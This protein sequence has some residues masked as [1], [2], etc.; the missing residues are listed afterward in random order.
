MAELKNKLSID[1]GDFVSGLQKAE[2]S[3]ETLVDK[4]KDITGAVKESGDAAQEAS[5]SFDLW[6][7]AV[8]SA[9]GGGVASVIQGAASKI[10]DFGKVAFDEYKKLDTSINNIGTL[11]VEA[12]GLSLDE[13]KRLATE[14]STSLPDTAGNIANGIYNAISAGIT[15]T[16]E[17]IAGFVEIAGKVAVAGLSDTNTAVNALTSV[18][19]AYGLGVEGADQVSNTF[20]AAIKAGKTSF[21]ELNAGLANVVPAASAAG[22]GFDEVAGSIAKLTTVG[23]PTSQATTQ[24]RSAIIEL[25]KPSKPLA[26]AL[27]K[28]GLDASNMA[29]ELAKPREQGGGLVN[30]LQR[31]EKSAAETGQSMTQI[32]SSSEAASAALSLTGKNAESTNQILKNVS[33][34]I[35]DNVAGKAFDAAAKS[36]DVQLKIFQNNIQAAFNSIF[37]AVIPVIETV[38]GI[39]TDVLGP[40]IGDFVDSIGQYFSNLGSILQP[41]LAVVGGVIIGSIVN[42]LNVVIN[43]LTAVYDIANNTFSAVVEAVRPLAEAF[44]LVGDESEESTDYVAAFKEALT[45]IGEVIK[46]VADILVGAFK[47]AIELAT[48]PLS[49]IA[50]VAA[51]VVDWFGSLFS[52]TKDVSKA[53]GDSVPFI[54]Q[55]RNVLDL[56]QKGAQGVINVF[57]VVKQTIIDVAKAIANL[58]FAAVLES[59]TGFGDKASAAYAKAFETKPVEDQT[60]TVEENT[61]AAD[62]NAAAQNKVADGLDKKGKSAKK[63]GDNIAKLT[64]ELRKLQLAEE[65]AAEIEAA[66]TIADATARQLAILEIEKKYARIGLEEELAAIKGNSKEAILQREILNAKLLAIDRDYE[67]K[68]QKVVSAENTKQFDQELALRKRT[69]ESIKK[70]NSELVASLQEQVGLGNVGAV[71]QLVA[72]NRAAIDQELSASIDAVTEST[73]EFKAGLDE[74]RRQLSVGLIDTDAARVQADLLRQTILE[75]LLAVPGDSD[76]FA[77]EIRKLY[78]DAAESVREAEAAVLDSAEESRIRRI[79]S[80]LLRDIALRVREIEKER[81]LLLENTELTEEQRKTI[82]DAYSDQIEAARRGPLRDFGTALEGILQTVESFT[83]DF[84][85]EEAVAASDEIKKKQEE[86]ND[87][88]RSGEISYQDAIERL[89]ELE[90]A[91]EQ[92]QSVLSQA[93]TQALQATAESAREQV[94][95]SLDAYATLQAES[96]KVAQDE[97]LTAD[98]KRAEL[99]SI[100]EK[101]A[102]QQ[103]DIYAQIGLQAASAF[104]S[105]VASGEDA[106]KSLVLIALDALQALIPIFTAQIFGINAASP[107]PANAFSFGAAG[108]AAAAATTAIL[109]GLVAA[110]RASVAGFKDGGYTGNVGVN[111]VAGVVHGREFVVNARATSKYR[112]I[113]EAMNSGKPVDI[114]AKDRNSGKYLDLNGGVSSMVSIMSDVRDRLDRIPDQAFTKQQVGLDVSLDERLYEKQRFR[115]QVRGLR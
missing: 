8:G 76:Q 12:A 14:L 3:T 100:S 9:I 30:V 34:D 115:K 35:Q 50:E 32:F 107:N 98:Q 82:Q 101:M 11:G 112:S 55:V 15:G 78:D 88:L 104:A 18:V 105:A 47:I 102:E 63:A 67:K 37:S 26:D 29:A 49:L 111:D 40:A 108:I 94:R 85:V 71:A 114:M 106:F 97:T 72:A 75:R 58:D 61:A 7:T 54:D 91:A 1:V 20:F 93:L 113:L 10:I 17:E 96:R 110:A 27:A 77:V 74:I 31:L 83:F 24:L 28:I 6:N 64:G 66:N 70:L 45:V 48:I 65:K 56:V 99:I 25:Q 73:P 36:I 57:G 92:T 86:I 95:L 60:K 90:S 42:A 69:N 38:L 4:L 21:E 39:F 62:E 43:A 22:V 33:A 46:T 23:I 89:N 51:S 44:G 80:D 84:N 5:G 79:S 103:T 87:A 16:E 2:K 52:E 59:L 53:M 13:F 81:D 41:I 19:N 109:Q 68:K